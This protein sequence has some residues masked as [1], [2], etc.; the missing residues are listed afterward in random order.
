MKPTDNLFRRAALFFVGTLIL[1]G[2]AA[3]GEK[4]S[5]DDVTPPPTTEVVEHPVAVVQ[6]EGSRQARSDVQTLLEIATKLTALRWALYANF[7]DNFNAE[8]GFNAGA[9]I[10]DASASGHADW[11]AYLQLVN[12]MSVNADAYVEALQRL[13]DNGIWDARKASTRAVN[14]PLKDFFMVFY[15]ADQILDSGHQKILD[16]M[17]S[18]GGKLNNSEEWKKLY[19]EM[20]EEYR[21]GETDYRQWR[22]RVVNKDYGAWNT[23]AFI[24]SRLFDLMCWEQDFYDTARDL[25]GDKDPRTMHMVNVGN[26]LTEQGMNLELSI[27]KTF[28]P[29]LSG[30]CDGIDLGKSGVTLVNAV[31]KGD[32]NETRDAMLTIS[33]V[34][35]TQVGGFDSNSKWWMGETVNIGYEA[36]RQT[37]FS[38]LSKMTADEN[39][40]GSDVGLINIKDLDN[41][42]AQVFIIDNG[43]GQTKVALATNGEATVPFT[44]NGTYTITGVDASGNTS[45]T[46]VGAQTGQN[47]SAEVDTKKKEDEDIPKNPRLSV[48]PDELSFEGDEDA[49][50]VTVNTN[51]RY[52]GV[53]AD[54]EWIKAVPVSGSNQ[55]RVSVPMNPTG[56][57]RT[58]HV[59]VMATDKAGNILRTVAVNVY[60]ERNDAGGV[61]P[62][63]NELRFAYNAY[64]KGFGVQLVDYEYLGAFVKDDKDKSWLSV[65]AGATDRYVTVYVE[66]NKTGTERRGTILV[67]GSNTLDPWNDGGYM[68][69]E[70]TVVQEAEGK[71]TLSPP[72]LSFPVEG[73]AATLTATLEGYAR[74]GSFIDTDGQGWLEVK[75]DGPSK[76]V[77]VTCKKNDTGTERT[78]HFYVFATNFDD[79]VVGDI[80]QVKVE[81]KQSADNS[82][83]YVSPTT[84]TYPAEGGT[85]NVTVNEAD[86]TRGGYSISN[87]GKGW[88]SVS[89]TSFSRGMDIT[90]QPNTTGQK[91]TC[92][93][94]CHLAMKDNPSADE[95]L[96][97]PIAITQEANELAPGE[98]MMNEIASCELTAVAMMKDRKKGTTA[99]TEYK[100]SFSSFTFTQDGSTVHV[101]GVNNY[102]EGEYNVYQNTIA[103]DIVNFSGNFATSKIE[104]LTFRHVYQD[105]YVD[106]TSPG[107]YGKGDEVDMELS[108]M[109]WQRAVSSYKNG[110]SSSFTYS[111]SVSTGVAFLKLTQKKVDEPTQYFDYVE[112]NNNRAMLVVKFQATGTSASRQQL[113]P[114]LADAQTPGGI[115][116]SK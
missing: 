91:R 98:I 73:G 56:K 2:F 89:F 87:E 4:S 8:S 94:N 49:M 65:S 100:Q 12:D 47:T 9:T 57:E 60:Q 6:Y 35:A 28:N 114:P 31:S 70:V 86:Y 42:G 113:S 74:L 41:T 21:F 16:V 5:G 27:Y 95:I 103:F 26:G 13:T 64:D 37:V 88:V 17:H 104:N 48:S 93:V 77:S 102:K 110:G 67:M 83:A 34:I 71:L 23:R 51:Y 106:W 15:N 62:D 36:M 112:N 55:V 107:F 10:P 58:G 22:N 63:T 3:C 29:A 25:S 20:P 115:V 18:N 69:V 108:N 44:K 75:P 39:A 79:P 82:K 61:I 76:T 40:L 54:Q 33:N 59:Y 92:T 97:L 101:Q 105:T 53:K 78:G 45:T 90:V 19:D 52:Y 111:G 81:V 80:K 72:S 68:S 30:F 38:D 85:Q 46:T 7:T 43:N 14:P 11:T 32:A 1:T 99:S 96:T 109:P 50:T 66:E 24:S 84:L 116:W